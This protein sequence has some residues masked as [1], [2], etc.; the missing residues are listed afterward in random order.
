MGSHWTTAQAGNRGDGEDDMPDAWR[1]R[2]RPDNEVPGALGSEVVLVRTDELA[3]FVLLQRAYSNG[4]DFSLEVRMRRVTNDG[5]PEIEDQVLFGVE[6]AD[7]RSCTLQDLDAAANMQDEEQPTLWFD[8]GSGSER[9]AEI[10]LFLSPLPP[11]GD[12]RFV[13]AWPQKAIPETTVVVPTD[14][15][16]QA[17]ARVEELW[18]WEPEPEPDARVSPRPAVPEGGWFAVHLPDHN[19]AGG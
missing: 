2:K 16:R 17:A 13:C 5:G 3:V 14:T 9:G 12:L 15:M 18:P 7:G 19:P 11:P 4:V 6:F 1:R 10:D 8:G